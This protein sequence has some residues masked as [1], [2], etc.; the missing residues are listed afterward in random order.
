M[1]TAKR[2]IWGAI[3]I[4]LGVLIAIDLLDIVKINLLF[5]GWWTLFIIIPCTV[6]LITGG[7]VGGNLLCIGIGVSL[8]L[9]AQ[10][11][12]EYSLIWKLLIPILIIAI[13]VSMIVRAIRKRIAREVKR[14]LKENTAPLQE[15]RV[16]FSGLKEN[17]AGR[18][19][20]G[21]EV[22]VAF[23]SAEL[24]LRDAVI[25]EDAVIKVSCAFGGAKI[26]LPEDVNYKGSYDCVFGSVSKTKRT[27]KEGRP[28]VYI[29]A[30]CAFGGC[31][32]K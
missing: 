11:I 28:T 9:A 16:A 26:L 27:N 29:G 20:N 24:D 15:Y 12:I 2:I 3:L 8:L 30:S 32:V 5:A 22:N 23:G 19:F 7:N 13:G 4:T 25:N 31:D 17:F 10:G 1:K 18:I 6:E 14:K 21:A